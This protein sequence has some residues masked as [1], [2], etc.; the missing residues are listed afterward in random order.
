HYMTRRPSVYHYGTCT[1]CCQA[2]ARYGCQSSVGWIYNGH[3]NTSKSL[4][5]DVL[6][7]VDGTNHPFFHLRRGSSQPPFPLEENKH[8]QNYHE[9]EAP[10]SRITVWPF[11]LRHVPKVHAIYSCN[12]SKWNKNGGYDGTHFH[13]GVHPVAQARL[14]QVEHA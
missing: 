13:N 2:R 7:A 6:R 1:H 3:Q 14:V 8:S 11:Q 5:R 10:N 4:Y 9:H 12:E